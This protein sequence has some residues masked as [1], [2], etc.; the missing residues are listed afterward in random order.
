MEATRVQ[1]N[2]CA[3]ISLRTMET[4]NEGELLSLPELI[5]FPEIEEKIL[6][7]KSRGKTLSLVQCGATFSNRQKND[8]PARGALEFKVS[9][10]LRDDKNNFMEEE[11]LFACNKD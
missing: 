7:L 8:R 1:A 2:S 6:A 3:A 10:K 5:D 4:K 9:K 11:A